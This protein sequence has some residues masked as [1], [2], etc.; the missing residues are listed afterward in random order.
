M[1]VC[2]DVACQWHH[3]LEDIPTNYCLKSLDV[4]EFAKLDIHP[5]SLILYCFLTEPNQAIN[6]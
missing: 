5:N 1:L 4:P 6:V 2:R 3:D